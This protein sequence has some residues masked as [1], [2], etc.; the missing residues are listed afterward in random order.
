MLQGL[1]WKTSSRT[2]E[3]FVFPVCQQTVAALMESC[4]KI[5][6]VLGQ[7]KTARLLCNGCHT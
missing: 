2:S 5:R 4:L 3:P 1:T 7:T 6:R